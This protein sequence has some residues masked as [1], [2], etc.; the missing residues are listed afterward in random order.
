[1]F[2]TVVM[3]I[4]TLTL[5]GVPAY[6]AGEPEA[7]PGEAATFTGV[8]ADGRWISFS[9][10]REA[11]STKRP[12]VLSALY[13][14]LG[15][16]QAFDAYSTV[17]GVSHGAREANP[18]MG[19]IAHKPA[20]MWAL[21]AGT[22]AISVF[23]AERMWRKNRTAAIVSMVIANSLAATVAANNARVLRQLR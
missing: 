18:L 17:H 22:T 20:G 14:S 16:L 4:L 1:M 15:A 10:P 13:V 7:T 21:K 11:E 9:A 23:A 3:T 5:A 6:A 19:G 12:A 8:T 2:R